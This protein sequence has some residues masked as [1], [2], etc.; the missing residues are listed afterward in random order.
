MIIKQNVKQ[1]VLKKIGEKFKK[2]M[3]ARNNA[4]KY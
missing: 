1:E 3:K 4:K 2:E